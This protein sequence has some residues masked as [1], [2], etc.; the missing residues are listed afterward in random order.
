MMVVQPSPI[1][2]DDSRATIFLDDGG[3]ATPICHQL[4]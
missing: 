1:C 4:R 2:S 3:V